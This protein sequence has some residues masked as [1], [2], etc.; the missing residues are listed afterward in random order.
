M[1][2]GLGRCSTS[3]NQVVSNDLIVE[4]TFEKELKDVMKKAMGQ[5]EAVVRT[6]AFTLSQRAGH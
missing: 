1:V 4:L 2:Q 3:L 6:L 5:S